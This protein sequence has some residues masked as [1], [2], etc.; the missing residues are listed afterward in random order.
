MWVV[1]VLIPAQR[2]DNVHIWVP[3]CMAVSF[4]A[5]GSVGPLV[6]RRM[7][8]RFAARHAEKKWT[9]RDNL[10]EPLN[11]SAAAGS[12]GHIA[13]SL[14]Q[15]QRA[16]EEAKADR[17]Y[18]TIEK[19]HRLLEF[20]RFKHPVLLTHML[21]PMELKESAVAMSRLCICVV[22]P[23]RLLSSS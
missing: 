16:L 20:A 22:C 21:R 4:F 8:P 5:Y 7:F 6:A 9:L 14:Y 23:L 12:L 17:D 13:A 3:L 11:V 1:H 10:L 18:C 19:T 15:V 2:H